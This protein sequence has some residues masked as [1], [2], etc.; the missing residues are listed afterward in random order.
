MLACVVWFFFACVKNKDKKGFRHSIQ[1]DMKG[2][3]EICLGMHS[4]CYVSVECSNPFSI[5]FLFLS[6]FNNKI[7]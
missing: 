2:G 7:F 5:F 4:L 1:Y 3:I 6:L